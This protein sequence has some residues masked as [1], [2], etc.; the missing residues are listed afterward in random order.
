MRLA[1][2]AGDEAR[3]LGAEVDDEDAVGHRTGLT[4]GAH[5]STLSRPGSVPHPDALRTLEELALG[6]E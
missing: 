2:P 1:N 3:V 5:G 4:G 6:L